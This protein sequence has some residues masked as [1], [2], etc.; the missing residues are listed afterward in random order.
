V[1]RA[2]VDET[3]EGFPKPDVVAEFQRQQGRGGGVDKRRVGVVLFWTSIGV[4]ALTGLAVL[5]AMNT[6]PPGVGDMRGIVY[7]FLIM[8]IA[9]VGIIV[10]AMIAIAASFYQRSAIALV[11]LDLALLFLCLSSALWR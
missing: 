1:N 10:S 5:V 4:L 6:E 9:L 7:G 3:P 8:G 11:L 2:N